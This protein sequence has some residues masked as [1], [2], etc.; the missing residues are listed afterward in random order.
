VLSTTASLA[1]GSTAVASLTSGPTVAVSSASFTKVFGDSNGKN[2]G[3]VTPSP[4]DAPKDV[5]TPKGCLLDHEQDRVRS[6]ELGVAGGTPVVLF[7]DSHAHQW[8][9][10]MDALA[11]ERGWDLSVF[12]K[13]GCPV[14][15]LK[16]INDGGRYSQPECVQWRSQAIDLITT[17]VKPQFIVVSSLH[18]YVSEADTML[19]AWD[20][21]L[22]KLRALDVP[23]VYI[24]DTPHPPSDVPTCISGAFD[25]WSKCAF[26][27]DKLQDL[28]VQKAI[29]GDEK[30]VTVVDLTPYF[31]DTDDTC[32]AVRNGYLLYRDE[33]HITGTAALALEP[34]L[35]QSMVQAGIIPAKN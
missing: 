31:C 30:N 23:I 8:A 27:K 26:P 10:A 3:S 9:P 19:A 22:D 13:A 12:A 34:V 20:R 29:T 4:L 5:R 14:A 18:T 32:A 24:R 35:E 21:S 15:D 6:C 11:K 16:P 33:S 2:S 17:Q 25:D 1:V 7:G 28:L